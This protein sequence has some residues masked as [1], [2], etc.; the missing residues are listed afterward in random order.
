M[1]RSQVV[2][3]STILILSLGFSTGAAAT[4]AVL[5]LAVLRGYARDAGFTDVEVL[6]LENDFFRFYRL[7]D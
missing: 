5:R 7:L 2:S 4:G 3:T 6:P 1:K